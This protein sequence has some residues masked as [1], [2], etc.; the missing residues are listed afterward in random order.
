MKLE[1]VKQFSFTA[2]HK[3]PNAPVEH[4]TSRPHEHTFRA[5]FTI[6]GEI[7]LQAQTGRLFDYADLQE[8][9]SELVEGSLKASYL[10]DIEGLENPT[11]ENIARWLWRRLQGRLPGLKRI[12][13]KESCTSEW[14]YEGN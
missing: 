10:N 12:S 5:D 3:L 4:L 2:L 8:A 14:K 11:S 9:V 6:E 13:L 1:L 7:D